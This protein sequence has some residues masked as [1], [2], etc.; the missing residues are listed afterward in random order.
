MVL[1]LKVAK[2]LSQTDPG[3]E[4]DT[5]RLPKEWEDVKFESQPE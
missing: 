5:K 1:V 4:G 2:F 3:M